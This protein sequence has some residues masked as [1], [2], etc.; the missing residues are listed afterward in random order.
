[1]K[2]FNKLNIQQICSVRSYLKAENDN[3]EYR[4]AKRFLF[5]KSEEGFYQYFFGDKVITK[6]EIESKGHLY[7]EGEKVFYKPHIEIRMSNQT[8]HCKYFD[9][10]EQLFDFMEQAEMKNVNWINN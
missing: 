9:T 10:K 7:V 4:K 2:S 1:M 3:Y 8:F 6:S 5:W